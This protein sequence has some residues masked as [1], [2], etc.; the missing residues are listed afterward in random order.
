MFNLAA[1]PFEAG[2][3]VLVNP[4][5][6]RSADP[7]LGDIVDYVRPQQDIPIAG[8]HAIYRIQGRG[9]DRILARAG[10]DVTSSHGELLVNGE[11]SPWPPLGAFQLPDNLEIT[12]PENCY[13]ILPGAVTQFPALL[14]T[15]SIVR[16]ANR[17]RDASIWRT[18][19]LWRFGPI[20]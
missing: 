2:D 3:V 11:P 8:R 4:S 5:A 15:L 20:R 18:Q 13:L 16:R 12:V 9:I 19:P 14:R 17:F 6:Y 10:D 1:P 7:Q